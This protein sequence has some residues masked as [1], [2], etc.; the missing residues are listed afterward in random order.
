VCARDTFRS[1]RQGLV[2]R[3]LNIGTD[4]EFEWVIMRDGRAGEGHGL[5]YHPCDSNITFFFR[6]TKKKRR[7]AGPSF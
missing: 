4:G 1:V 5:R 7:C 2:P 6:A 3:F